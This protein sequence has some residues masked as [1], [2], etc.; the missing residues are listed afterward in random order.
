MGGKGDPD[1][2]GFEGWEFHSK[3]KPQKDDIVIQKTTPDSF[4]KTVSNELLQ[5]KNVKSLIILSLQ[6]EYCIDTTIR[7]AYT[8][9]YDVSLVKD[10][11]ST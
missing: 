6:T 1:E 7:R 5:T 4:D 2:P 9:G 3:I 11:H 8:L 10:C